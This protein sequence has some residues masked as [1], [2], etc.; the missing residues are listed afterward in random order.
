MGQPIFWTNVGIDVQTALAPAISLSAIS[1]AT[2]GVC[3]YT[4]G[5]NP[6]NGDYI[7]LTASGMSQVNDRPFRIANVNTTTKTFE[8]ENEDTTAYDTFISGSFQIITFGASFNSVQ[9]I[10]PSGGDY[11]KADVTTI[12]D[13]VRKNVPTIAAPLTLGMTNYFDL[14]DPGFMECNKA[15]KSK[16]K[17]AIRLRFGTGA[18]MLMVGYVGAAGVPTGQAQGVVQTPVSIEAQNLPTVYAS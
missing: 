10:S 11:E 5:T 2:T 15:Y 17:R 16:T 1:K 13:Q 8:L 3:T 12:H 4:G 7:V 18:K 14:A 9:Q 6:A